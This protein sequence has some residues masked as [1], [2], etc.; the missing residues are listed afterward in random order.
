M[1][2]IVL[3]GVEKL[4]SR[5]LQALAKVGLEANIFVVDPSIESQEI[6]KTSYDEMPHYLVKIF[7]R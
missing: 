7:Y 3:I 5:H 6:A 4:G 1:I 2:N